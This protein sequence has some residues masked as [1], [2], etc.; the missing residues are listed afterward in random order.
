MSTG[1]AEVCGMLK[2]VHNDEPKHGILESTV[3]LQS[4]ISICRYSD[5][6]LR[7]EMVALC[8]CSTV[9]EAGFSVTL[10]LQASVACSSPSKVPA[11]Q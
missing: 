2:L 8:T 4:K 10:W 3:D 9:A 6:S 1:D 7:V 5:L 11:D